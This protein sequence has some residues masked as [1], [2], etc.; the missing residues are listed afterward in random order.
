[1]GNATS[2]ICFR[3]VCP[4]D[5]EQLGHLFQQQWAAHLPEAAGKLAGQIDICS[6]L[7]ET[8]WSLAAERN[9]LILGAALL[10]FTDVAPDAEWASR[11]EKLLAEAARDPEL[12]ADVRRDVDFIEEEAAVSADYI[13]GGGVGAGAEL[14]LLIVNPDAK[15]MGLGA[16][17]F[18]AACEIAA[19]HA[20][21]IF[22]VTDDDCDFGFYE[23]KGMERRVTREVA[24]DCHIYVYAQE[25]S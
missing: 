19:A 12:L 2:G 22:L 3:A 11:R 24:D 6:Y 4:R 21:G 13:S 25:L 17:L 1:M 9:G 5:L 18:D 16:H 14:K 8:N 20:G 7:A 15:G 10:S 23:H